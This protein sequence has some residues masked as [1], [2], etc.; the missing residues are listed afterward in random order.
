[1]HVIDQTKFTGDSSLNDEDIADPIESIE[2]TAKPT[3]EKLTLNCY[4]KSEDKCLPLTT[5]EAFREESHEAGTTGI[6]VNPDNMHFIDMKFSPP[7]QHSHF[8]R[9]DKG[10][11]KQHVNPSKSHFLS[12]TFTN[13][14]LHH[15][16]AIL[17]VPTFTPVIIIW[18]NKS[19]MDHPI[20]LHGYK[21]EILDI[22]MPDRNR[23]CTRADC[24]LPTKY[25]H[26]E[27]LQQLD[28]NIPYGRAVLKDTFILP[29]GGAVV[30]RIQT[31][32]PAVWF[33][34]CHL[35]THRE[36]GMAMILNVG[37]YTAPSNPEW[38]PDDFPSC[39]DHFVQTKIDHPA[40]TCHHNGDMVLAQALTGDHRCS[41]DY[42]CMH[43]L[44][45]AANLDHYVLEGGGV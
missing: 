30:A 28:N 29:A 21:M 31:K 13:D 18:R 16:T 25:N 6:P 27:V 20:H 17:H 24:I 3:N 37:N 39:S 23:D 44:S 8:M 35:E 34:H 38:L 36:D 32:S 40:C 1:M 12:H 26:P 9:I 4:S 45:E 14:D 42:L 5:L 22:H 41:R 19:L 33:A 11:W 7:P 43:E 2:K 10:L 15:N